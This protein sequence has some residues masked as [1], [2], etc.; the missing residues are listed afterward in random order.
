M[1][2]VEPGRDQPARFVALAAG[3][4]EADIWPGAE[5]ERAM[6]AAVDI[7]GAPELRPVWADEQI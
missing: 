1:R 5:G 4:G 2:R 7:V 6:L 3:V